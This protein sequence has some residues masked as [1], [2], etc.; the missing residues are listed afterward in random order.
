L[1]TKYLFLFLLLFFVSGCAPVVERRADA[2]KWVTSEKMYLFKRVKTGSTD[3][4]GVKIPKYGNR[5][6]LSDSAELTG[7]DK[8]PV[9][10]N[11]LDCFSEKP[12]SP[13]LG[14]TYCETQPIKYY[15]VF[16][17]KWEV[18]VSEDVWKNHTPY[19]TYRSREDIFGNL[20]IVSP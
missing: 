19:T 14:D 20:R 17:D 16:G 5:W 1:K 10:P 11:S 4:G 12:E 3:V 8:N 18:E 15:L 9:Q 7:F 2:A 13:K 6:R